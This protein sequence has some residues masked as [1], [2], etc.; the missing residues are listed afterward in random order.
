MASRWPV[1]TDGGNCADIAEAQRL[2][3]RTRM[4]A[5]IR[6]PDPDRVHEQGDGSN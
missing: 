1:E 3:Y 5:G 6:L 4:A 2:I